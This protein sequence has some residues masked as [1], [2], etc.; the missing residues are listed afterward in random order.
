VTALKINVD[1]GAAGAFASH[2]GIGGL[3]LYGTGSSLDGLT[4]SQILA[5]AQQALAGGAFPAGFDANSFAGFLGNY[6]NPSFDQCKPSGWALG[7][8]K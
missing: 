4:V 7:H 6:L 8:L 3:K 1:L 2:P 5:V